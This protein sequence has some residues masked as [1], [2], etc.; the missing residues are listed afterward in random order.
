METFKWIVEKIDV[1]YYGLTMKKCANCRKTIPVDTKRMEGKEWVPICNM[2]CY[3]S[4][5]AKNPETSK[6]K[7]IS[8][9]N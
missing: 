4:W 5:I 3:Q 9:N 2:G 1:Y 7:R 6:I 8:E